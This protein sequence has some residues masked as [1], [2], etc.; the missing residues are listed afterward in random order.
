V[1]ELIRL[2]PTTGLKILPHWLAQPYFRVQPTSTQ[3]AAKREPKR[4]HDLD[5]GHESEVEDEKNGDGERWRLEGANS[6]RVKDPHLPGPSSILHLPSEV[7]VRHRGT[8]STLQR[9]CKQ[10]N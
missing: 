3:N 8:I 7:I 1:K 2:E 4:M 9:P 5:T 6:K 10:G